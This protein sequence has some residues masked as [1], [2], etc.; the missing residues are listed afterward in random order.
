VGLLAA[1]L[2]LRPGFFGCTPVASNKECC[3]WLSVWRV[4][5]KARGLNRSLFVM[6]PAAAHCL[7]P[8]SPL[9]RRASLPHGRGVTRAC[10]EHT[11][12]THGGRARSPPRA[13]PL[14][15]GDSTAG[16]PPAAPP[17]HSSTSTKWREG[18]AMRQLRG[19]PPLRP[20]HATLSNPISN[21]IESNPIQSNPIRSNPIQSDPIASNPIQSNP[22]QSNP[23]Q[24]HPIQ[25]NSIRSNPIQSNPIASNP[26]QSDPIQSNPI[27][28]DP[29][30]SNPIQ[31]DPI[32]PNCIQ[33]C[34]S[35]HPPQTTPHPP[36]NRTKE[37]YDRLLFREALKCAAYDLANARDVYR[38]GFGA[39]ACLMKLATL[40]NRGEV[41]RAQDANCG[42]PLLLMGRR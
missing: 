39:A 25:P 12:P 35:T 22:I 11:A 13:Q 26:I 8:R 32:Q 17:R 1:W 24:L 28:S 36:P 38:W 4:A 27:Q 9:S 3:S 20:L 23:I 6:P 29:I 37:A 40:P 30:Q 7:F 34:L 21:P 41:L 5:P 31:S 42:R 10:A 15:W 19:R 33:S 2:L 16:P 18:P 14:C